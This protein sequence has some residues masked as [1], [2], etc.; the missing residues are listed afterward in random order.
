MIFNEQSELAKQYN[1]ADKLCALVML[2]HASQQDI[3]FHHII[4]SS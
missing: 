4:I 2:R 1:D 3:K